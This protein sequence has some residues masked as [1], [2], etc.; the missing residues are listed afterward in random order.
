MRAL[1]AV[2][3]AALLL[4]LSACSPTTA[5]GSGDTSAS[6][7]DPSPTAEVLAPRECAIAGSPWSLDPDAYIVAATEYEKYST[8]PLTGVTSSGSMQ[9]RFSDDAV[10][11]SLADFTVVRTLASGASTF[12]ITW[13][14]DE[15]GS[16]T[17]VWTDETTLGFSGAAYSRMDALTDATLD[18]APTTNMFPKALDF[19]LADDSVLRVACEPGRLTLDDLGIVWEFVSP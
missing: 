16:A 8:F 17:A 19:P 15:E 4:A 7:P 1:S 14:L 13:T 12:E 10:A 6:E 2:G 18:G 5:S 3:T 11:V 9:V